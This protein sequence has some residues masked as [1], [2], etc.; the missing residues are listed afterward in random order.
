MWYMLE[1]RKICCYYNCCVSGKTVQGI[2]HYNKCC[3]QM[4]CRPFCPYDHSFD[5]SGVWIT[6]FHDQ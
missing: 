3:L 1:Q 2:K 6:W 5:N 4:L